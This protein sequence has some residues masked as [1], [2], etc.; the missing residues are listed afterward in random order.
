M[1]PFGRALS[2][3]GGCVYLKYK[4]RE[5]ELLANKL[6]RVGPGNNE[7][8]QGAEWVRAGYHGFSLG[9]AAIITASGT[10]E[11]AWPQLPTR[12]NSNKDS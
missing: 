5:K 4:Q 6:S 3:V 7:A 11:A 8:F 2:G 9:F 12:R 1:V 10:P